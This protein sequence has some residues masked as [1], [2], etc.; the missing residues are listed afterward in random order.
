VD[1]PDTQGSEHTPPATPAADEEKPQV[2]EYTKWMDGAETTVGANQE[3]E[4]KKP[5]VSEYT[6]WMDGAETAMTDEDNTAETEEEQKDVE[7]SVSEADTTETTT[8]A[9]QESLAK[10]EEKN[11]QAAVDEA[12]RKESDLQKDLSLFDPEHA[13][14]SSLAGRTISKRV[15]EFN[16]KITFFDK[17]D[18]DSTRLGKWSHWKDSKT[19]LFEGGDHCW[20]GPSRSLVVKF[21]CGIE[22]DILDVIEPSRCVYEASVVAPAACDQAELDELL[23]STQKV[24]GPRDEL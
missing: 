21:Q 16:Y 20:Q 18:Q 12:K 10:V 15:S 5:E 24:V 14:Y 22:E 6:K 8:Q 1:A 11:A 2:S 19:A 3:S 23:G 4:E 13:A 7:A 17:A 9:P